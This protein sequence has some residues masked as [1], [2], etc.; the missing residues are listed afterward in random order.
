M[1]RTLI[2]L[3]LAFAFAAVAWAGTTNYNAL[4][5]TPESTDTYPLLIENTSGT[6]LIRSTVNEPVLYLLPTDTAPTSCAAEGC[7][8]WDDS[9]N[10]LKIYHTA[11]WHAVAT[12]AGTMDLDD[13]YN[14]GSA[15][16]ADTDAVTITVSDTDNNVGLI[17]A[18]NDSTNDP[19]A[20]QITSAANAANAIALDI[21]AQATGRDIEGTGASWYVTGAGAA[22]FA[23]LAYSGTLSAGAISMTGSITMA[24][25][26]VISADTNNEIEF[27]DN[28][29]EFSFAFT[30]NTVTLATDTGID[31]LAFGDVDALTGVG[32]IAFDADATTVTLAA[33]GAADDLTISVTGAQDASLVLSSAGTAADAMQLTTTAGGIDITNGGAAGGEDLDLVSSNAS[34]NLTSAEAVADAIVLTASANGG[35][36][37]LAAQ[38]DIDLTMTNGA[39]G[40]DITLSN[41]GGSIV[42]TASEAATDAINIDSTAGGID[43]DAYDTL[44]IDAGGAGVT[45]DIIIQI[46]S[47]S[48]GEDLSI[49]Q[50]GAVDASVLISAAGTGTDAIKLN[51][52]AGGIDIDANAQPLNITVTST[53]A[54]DDLILAQVG[55][56]D[57]S[58]ALQAAGTGTDAIS[59]QA[60]AGGIDI[61]SVADLIITNTAAAGADDFVL[62]QAGAFDASLLLQSAGTGADAI[63]LSASAGGITISAAGGSDILISSS[64]DVDD[65]IVG[66]GG[67]AISGM[68]FTVTNDAD[69][70][71]LTI[72]EAQTL[73]T[74]AGAVGGGVWNLPEASTAIGMCFTFVTMA[75]Q[76]LDI[77]PDDADTILVLTNAAGDALRNATAGNSIVL[78]AM[79]ATNWAAVGTAYGTWTDVN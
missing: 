51:A 62:A 58:I 59:I 56:N 28:S 35:G 48:A 52:T 31:T 13:A 15:I 69:G 4:T 70:K 64:L 16:D 72:A 46:T 3:A 53:G 33:D 44:S 78:C 79:D 1:R 49:A 39:A 63:G 40:E 41:T 24:N 77:N 55:A 18:Q 57:S 27:S 30:S 19:T 68:L 60:S 17:V 21:D 67:A 50:V 32:G 23:S 7:F 73:Q 71:T 75:A 45:D 8:Y 14:N 37:D 42:L 12:S 5:L 36:I 74:N 11:A 20:V 10:T 61:D 29:E 2:L 26:Q 76:N 22:T 9:E 6:D 66:D 34:I 25:G 43:I 38:N 54:A 65:T 47:A